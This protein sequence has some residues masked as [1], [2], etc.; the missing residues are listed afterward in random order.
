MNKY[1]SQ[2]IG[3]NLYTYV[4]EED[5]SSFKLVDT[6][7]ANKGRAGFFRRGPFAKRGFGE[8]FSIFM[9]LSTSTKIDK[10]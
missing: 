4:H 7:P 3:N 9:L 5:E 2:F 1:Q 8:F 6:T 10:I